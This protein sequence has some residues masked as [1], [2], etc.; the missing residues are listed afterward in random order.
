MSVK[1]P[2]VTK[3]NSLKCT[4]ILINFIRLKIYSEKIQTKLYDLSLW[5]LRKTTKN[6]KIKLEVVEIADKNAF[7]ESEKVDL[8][9]R[10]RQMNIATRSNSLNVSFEGENLN[11]N[12][13]DEICIFSNQF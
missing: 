10:T 5:L 4:I 2:P 9:G 13:D 6:T 3:I 7:S 12:N 1:I 8:F 11:N